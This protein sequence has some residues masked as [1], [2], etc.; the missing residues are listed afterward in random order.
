MRETTQ[1]QVNKTVTSKLKCDQCGKTHNQ[2]R[3]G[4]DQPYIHEI[5]IFPGYGSKFDTMR[6][7]I[8]LCDDCLKDILVVLGIEARER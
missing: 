3:R 1:I 6:I 8:D 2:L 7:S 5:D 4:F